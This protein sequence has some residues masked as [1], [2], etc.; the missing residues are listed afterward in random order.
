MQTGGK[1]P[2]GRSGIDGVTVTND[3]WEELTLTWMG[4][5]GR[6]TEELQTDPQADL[7]TAQPLTQATLEVPTEPHTVLFSNPQSSAQAGRASPT[8]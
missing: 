3:I 6:D 5:Q 8:W 1:C 2:W 7:G 4:G